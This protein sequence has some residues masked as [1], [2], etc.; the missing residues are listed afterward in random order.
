MRVRR[1]LVTSALILGSVGIGSA[2][3]QGADAPATGS[4]TPTESAQWKSW[5]DG[6]KPV[7]DATSSQLVDGGYA[8]VPINPYRNYDS[9]LYRDGRILSSEE[10]WGDVLTDKFGVPQIPNTAVAVTYN[11]TVT[12]TVGP[13]FLGVF[14]SDIA[15]PGNASVNWT[16]S[17]ATVGNSGTTAIGFLDADGQMSLYM[18]GVPGGSTDFIIDITG[19]YQ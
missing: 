17:G 6:A 5:P 1:Y 10:L 15:W 3:T 18:G 12:D 2:I 4:A 7:A 16:G 13:G 14:P 9:R 8:F 11:L 19:F